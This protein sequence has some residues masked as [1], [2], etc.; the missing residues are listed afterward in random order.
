VAHTQWTGQITLAGD[1][2]VYRDN[3]AFHKPQ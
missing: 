3:A 1:H 2:L